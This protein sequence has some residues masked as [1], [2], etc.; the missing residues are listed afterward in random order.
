VLPP[1]VGGNLLLAA[2]GLASIG[3]GLFGGLIALIPFRRREAWAWWALW[4]YPVFSTVHLRRSSTIVTVLPWP[5]VCWLGHSLPCSAVVVHPSRP[6]VL[7][8]A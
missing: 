5:V 3:L 2:T 8:P 4:F 7:R 6:T 1:V